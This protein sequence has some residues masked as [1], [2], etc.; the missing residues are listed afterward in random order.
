MEVLRKDG[1]ILL[2]EM[3]AEVKNF[4]DFKMNAVMVSRVKD[5]WGDQEEDGDIIIKMIQLYATTMT[6]GTLCNRT[7]L[8]LLLLQF[9]KSGI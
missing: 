7:L 6:P 2:R 5:E 8:L 9:P 3:A 1:I 4:M